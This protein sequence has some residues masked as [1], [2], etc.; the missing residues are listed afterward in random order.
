MKSGFHRRMQFRG[1]RFQAHR[2]AQGPA[3][4]IKTINP[5]QIPLAGISGFAIVRSELLRNPQFWIF[6]QQLFPPLPK[7]GLSGDRLNTMV[8]GSLRDEGRLRAIKWF[9]TIHFDDACTGIR[10]RLPHIESD[11]PQSCRRARY[12]PKASIAHG[13]RNGPEVVR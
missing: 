10:A 4:R 13:H 1:D 7:D 3:L 2:N 5:V 8:D 12:C 6:L 9:R 11:Q